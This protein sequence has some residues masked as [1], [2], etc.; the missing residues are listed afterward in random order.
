MKSIFAMTAVAMLAIPA[1]AQA[2]TTGGATVVAAAEVAC[3]RSVIRASG[4]D[5]CGNPVV[6]TNVRPSRGF[7]RSRTR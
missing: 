7:S 1:A 5:F 6:I 4:N 3:S 2:Q